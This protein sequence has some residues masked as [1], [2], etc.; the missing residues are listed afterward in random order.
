MS[1]LHCVTMFKIS[2]Y[3]MKL[4]L[5]G[6]TGCVTS[7]TLPRFQETIYVPLQNREMKA[8]THTGRKS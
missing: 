1:Y 8:A 7:L 2:T 3:E 6:Y 5:S 4:V